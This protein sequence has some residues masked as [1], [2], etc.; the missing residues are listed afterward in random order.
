[1]RLKNFGNSGFITPHTNSGP[2]R[3]VS[4]NTQKLPDELSRLGILSVII[5]LITRGSD[6]IGWI[7]QRLVLG[8]FTEWEAISK[9]VLGALNMHL[10]RPP[11][12]ILNTNVRETA[13]RLG[14]QIVMGESAGDTV[15]N[16]T[17]DEI[18]QKTQSILAAWD[19]PYPCL[20]I[21]VILFASRSVSASPALSN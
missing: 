3:A 8:E 19:R 15:P 2:T 20:L 13:E 21:P 4:Q 9:R 1:M 17:V 16:I 7:R 12:L 10:F 5:L 11:Y 18:K 6:G 14:Y